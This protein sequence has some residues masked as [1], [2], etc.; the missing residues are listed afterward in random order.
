MEMES[1]EVYPPASAQ[2]SDQGIEFMFG[3]AE[4]VLLQACSD[5]FV[6]MGIYVRVYPDHD[7]RFF[8]HSSGDTVDDFYFRKRFA[9][10]G[11]DTVSDGC[12]YLFVSLS[13]P[14]ENYLFRWETACQGGKDFIAADTVSA[15]SL[16]GDISENTVFGIGLDG[17]MGGD[18][19]LRRQAY[20]FG[21]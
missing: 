14:C 10:H 17:I 4:L 21:D 1:L 20:H 13:N 9:V 8:P 16:R 18:P 2:K 6:C 19:V 11:K 12:F 5:V 3:N 7:P 15:Q